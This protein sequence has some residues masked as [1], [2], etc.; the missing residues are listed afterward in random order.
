MLVQVPIENNHSHLGRMNAMVEE[1]K[2]EA[3]EVEVEM[4]EVE[5]EDLMEKE[6]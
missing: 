6:G 3:L 4:E 5:E 2:V 1:V